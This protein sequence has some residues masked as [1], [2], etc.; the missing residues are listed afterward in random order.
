MLARDVVAIAHR[1]AVVERF[2]RLLEE[3][4]FFSEAAQEF[5]GK[6]AV[7]QNLLEENQWILGVS[8]AGQV[9]TNWNEEKL[10]Q[11][12]AGFSIS[13]PGKRTDALMQT[14]GKIK[15]LVF[16]EIKH[17]QTDLLDKKEYKKEY[18]PGAWA[19]SSE[20]SGGVTQIQQTV[21][22]AVRQIGE[23]LPET[24]ESGAETGEHTYLIRPRSF[25]ILGNLEQLRGP[26]GVHRAKYES[27]ELYR[28]N[29]YEPEIITF[30]ELLA[31]AEWHVEV[32]DEESST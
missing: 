1:Q 22:L 6:E 7:W 25:L 20:L 30:D 13:G 24:D 26:G 4:R 31:R 10:E 12:V 29:L 15:A 11:V 27:F 14:S 19:P 16:V 18:R 17:H 5:G 21:R 23:R 8:L 32:L 3:P 2:R 28:R 9:L